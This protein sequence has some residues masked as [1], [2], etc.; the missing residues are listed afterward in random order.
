MKYF[1]NHIYFGD[2]PRCVKTEREPSLEFEFNNFVF[3]AYKFGNFWGVAQ[4]DCGFIVNSMSRYKTRKLAITEA[5]KTLTENKTIIGNAVA[6]R[7]EELANP[8]LKI[9]EV[10]LI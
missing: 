9:E 7:L 4:K 2:P 3:F 5:I 8:N 10:E 1:T 6:A